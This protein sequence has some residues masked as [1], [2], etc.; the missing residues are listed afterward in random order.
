MQILRLLGELS[1]AM[2]LCRAVGGQW[3]LT[4]PHL[5]NQR[6]QHLWW[7]QEITAQGCWHS[8]QSWKQELIKTPHTVRP[9]AVSPKSDNVHHCTG[10]NSEPDLY[11]FTLRACIILKTH[12][13]LTNIQMP[14]AQR[15]AKFRHVW[16]WSISTP[17]INAG[18]CWMQPRSFFFYYYVSHT[19]FQMNKF[20]LNIVTPFAI[21]F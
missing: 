6:I 12:G 18:T 21:I 1:S 19:G 17:H 14:H 15:N 8:S 20:L 5:V 4:T 13:D 11:L 10:L 16:H 9:T 2:F 3:K 7:C